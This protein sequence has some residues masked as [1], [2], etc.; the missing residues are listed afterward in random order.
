MTIRLELEDPGLVEFTANVL[1]C[2]P[3]D[4]GR[5][6]VVLD[7]SAF[8]PTGGGQPHDTGTLGSARVVD[9]T[10]DGKTVVHAV[11]GG[12]LSGAV[13]GR[14]DAARRRDHRQQ[15]TGQHVLSAVFA[16]ECG[17]H[18][19]SFHLGAD[20]STI[21][22]DKPVSAEDAAR[23]ENAANDVVERDL[24]V[25]V[26]HASRADLESQRLRKINV[27]ED[28]DVVRIVAIGDV[29][30]SHCGGTHCHRT[31]EIRLVK[32]IGVERGKSG[33]TRVAFLCGDRALKDLAARYDALAEAARVATSAWTEVPRLLG[34]K[35]AALKDAEKAAK[36]FSAEIAAALAEATAGEAP[37]C[38]RFESAPPAFCRA[39]ATDLARR[40]RRLALV[41]GP[42]PAEAG[43][44]AA[45]L[46][47]PAGGR[48]AGEAVRG[49]VLRHGGRG[50]GKGPVAQMDGLS[51]AAFDAMA[52]ELLTP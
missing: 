47:F 15:H 11:E 2:E 46:A 45:V 24:L 33:Q 26:T 51:P 44:I 13:A 7:R 34:A 3:A 18:T 23:A 25:D 31:A 6:K 12:P 43:K 21:D 36:G 38:R 22:L 39:L 10:L 50:G 4:S 9:V 35:I 52:T 20:H 8:Y 14:V 37:Y 30:R 5:H 42:S 1:S 49:L 27:P 16:S 41:G 17:A 32:V 28:V 19:A 29:D 40:G 48:D